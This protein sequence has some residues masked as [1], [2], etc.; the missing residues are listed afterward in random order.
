MQ[1]FLRLRS[2]I[3]NVYTVREKSAWSILDERHVKVLELELY[4]VQSVK[5]DTTAM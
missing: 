1:N 2:W 5:P 4:Q 3:R